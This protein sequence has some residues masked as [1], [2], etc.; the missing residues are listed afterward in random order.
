L[1]REGISGLTE[2]QLIYWRAVIGQILMNMYFFRA[3]VVPKKTHPKYEE[4]GGGMVNC[5]IKRETEEQAQAV[6]RGWIGD[7]DW[8][9]VRLDVAGLMTR[10]E[11][12]INPAALE[13]FEQAE[14]DNEVFVFLTW[15]REGE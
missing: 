1:Q 4:Y 12:M 15:R 7:E 13:Y 11:Q 10:E 2:E 5:W 3:E 14:I 8:K 9:I 6:A